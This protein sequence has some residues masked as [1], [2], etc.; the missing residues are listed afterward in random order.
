MTIIQ[1]KI[2]RILQE[3]PTVRVLVID[4][5][6]QDFSYL[7]GQ[8]VDC[9]VDIDGKRE[10]VGYSLTSNPSTQ[11]SIELAVK[12]SENPVSVYVHE[13]AQM[14][15]ILWIEGGQGDVYYK[16]GMG[17]KVVLIA[18]GIG[19]APLVGI[20]RY[21]DENTNSDVTLI[22]SASTGNEMLYYQEINDRA[23]KNSRLRYYPFVTREDPQK[24]FFKGR[25]N[26]KTLDKICLDLCSI[27][28]ISGPGDMI[29]M[30]KSY[31]KNRG[32]DENRIKYEIWW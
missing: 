8:W 30:L 26:G 32:V 2:S 28:F 4:L 13:K 7:A 3:T 5:Q 9:Y 27:F 1:V 11:K 31:L 20:L 17:E 22:Q 21:I 24:G 12:I 15:D 6:D 29:P 10:M 18:A 14:G 25:I 19:V 16:V 23:E